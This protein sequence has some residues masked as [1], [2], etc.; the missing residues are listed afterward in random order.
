MASK[1]CRFVDQ[2]F[3]LLALILAEFGG[4][5]LMFGWPWTWTR[6]EANERQQ[7]CAQY[8]VLFRVSVQ[9]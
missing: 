5:S 2:R 8:D 1:P 3:E 7:A 6:A 4:L 9:F